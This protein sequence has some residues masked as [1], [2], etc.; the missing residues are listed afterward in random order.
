MIAGPVLYPLHDLLVPG[1]HLGVVGP[2]GGEDFLV[3]GELGGP[4][5]VEAGHD[6]GEVVRL[7]HL[8]VGR[9]L[10]NLQTKVESRGYQMEI[11]SETD[12]VL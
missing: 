11:V 12:L 2:L 3:A 6:H 1:L 8:I 10:G 5:Q 4:A 7:D 9:N